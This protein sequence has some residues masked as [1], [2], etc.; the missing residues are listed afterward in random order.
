MKNLSGLSGLSGSELTTEDQKILDDMF[1]ATTEGHSRFEIERASKAFK[2]WCDEN[3]ER[4]RRLS[5]QYFA[6]RWAEMKAA[7]KEIA[8]D[9]KQDAKSGGQA[10][11]VLA[12]GYRNGAFN[13]K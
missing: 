2:E 10:R 12:K 13:G 5:K 1:K 6:P 3:P 7:L 4:N 9:P 11:Y 8:D